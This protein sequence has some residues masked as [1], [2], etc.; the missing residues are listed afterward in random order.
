MNSR[1]PFSP[2]LV[3]VHAHA[4]LYVRTPDQESARHRERE[5]NGEGG[6]SGNVRLGRVYHY[7]GE[8]VEGS[9]GIGRWWNE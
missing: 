7:T 5:R 1:S 6:R 3:G 2:S 4:R 8:E 9:I